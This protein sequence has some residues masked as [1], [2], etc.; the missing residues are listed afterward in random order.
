MTHLHYDWSHNY[1]VLVKGRKHVVLYPPE[2]W[3]NVYLYPFLHPN[4]TKSQVEI[5]NPDFSRYPDFEKANPVEVSVPRLA[6]RYHLITTL[7]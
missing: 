6:V 1:K 3:Q 4:K 5:T 7:R 2:D